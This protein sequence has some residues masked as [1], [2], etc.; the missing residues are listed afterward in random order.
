MKNIT[1]LVTASLMLTA[2]GPRVHMQRN[3]P[4][5]PEELM[6][7]CPDLV[8]TPETDKLSEVLDVVAQNYGL[9]HRCQDRNGKWIEWYQKQKEIF[10]KVK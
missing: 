7:E 1:L 4:P 10:E 3:F 5:A 6:V 8:Q 9:Y 2:C